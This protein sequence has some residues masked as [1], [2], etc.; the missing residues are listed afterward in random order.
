MLGVLGGTVFSEKEGFRFERKQRIRTRYGRVL[1]K[2]GK[3]FAFIQRHGNPKKP[4]HK[5]NHKANI[6]ALKK[7]GIT[8]IIG[9]N[10]AG[11]LKKS[12]KPGSLAVPHDFMQ[13]FPKTFFNNKIVH[14]TP[15]LSNRLRRKIIVACKRLN[16]PVI[17]RAVYFQTIGPRLETPSEVRFLSNFADLVGMTMA[18][19]ATLAVEQGLEYASI[20]TVDNYAYGIARTLSF[21]GIK[22]RAARNVNKVKRIVLEMVKSDNPD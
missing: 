13:F 6:Y 19:E 10:S 9:I 15:K 17:K 11:S 3:G 16:I 21:E 2:F 8:E 4:P 20:C 22:K 12:I 1:V 18:D 7:L 14:V 5:I